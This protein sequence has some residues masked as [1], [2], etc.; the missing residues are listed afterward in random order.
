MVNKPWKHV[1]LWILNLLVVNVMA[2]TQNLFIVLF[3]YVLSSCQS[4]QSMK[5][6]EAVQPI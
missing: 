3:I 2:W 5:D 4:N 6:I 1:N